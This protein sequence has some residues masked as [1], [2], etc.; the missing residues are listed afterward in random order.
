MNTVVPPTHFYR[1]FVH[2]L[3]NHGLGFVNGI[4][5]G[6]LPPSLLNLSC[7]NRHYYRQVLRASPP[8]NVKG[9]GRD[10]FPVV[11]HLNRLVERP[12]Y[13]VLDAPLLATLFSRCHA[14]APSLIVNPSSTV[15]TF[16]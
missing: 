7:H 9:A 11:G 6:K 5:G 14:A 13:C 2:L 10:H 3:T 16:L 4:E 8:L 15:L 1:E 12:Q